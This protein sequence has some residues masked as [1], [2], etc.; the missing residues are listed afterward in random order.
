MHQIAI[1]HTVAINHAAVPEV[2]V[3]RDVAIHHV[4]MYDA[5]FV[6]ESVPVVQGFFVCQF[7]PDN[8]MMAEHPAITVHIM[9]AIADHAVVHIMHA[10]NDNGFVH[11][12]IEVKVVLEHINSMVLAYRAPS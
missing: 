10:A 3:V 4:A 8:A 11:A 5:A 2:P 7:M 12:M 6:H 9:V 1:V